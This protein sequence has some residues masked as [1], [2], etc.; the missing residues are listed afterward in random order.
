LIFKETVNAE[1][2]QL[3]MVSLHE[4]EEEEPTYMKIINSTYFIDAEREHTCQN[5]KWQITLVIL[6][7][8]CD[9]EF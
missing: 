5:H 8:P 9:I 2:K 3:N 6:H 1:N 4:E 7:C